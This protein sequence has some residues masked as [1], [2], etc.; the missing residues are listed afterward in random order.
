MEL[1]VAGRTVSTTEAVEVLQ[2]YP[3]GTIRWY[4][5]A[6]AGPEAA[7]EVTLADLGRLAIINAD[8]SG[9]DAV[10]LLELGRSAPW[11]RVATD[12]DLVEAD[13]E[14][15]GGLYDDAVALYDHFVSH[16]GI[17]PAKASKLLHLKRPHLYPILDSQVMAFYDRS[18]RDAAAAS[19]REAH[20]MYWAAIRNDLIANQAAL[21]SLRSE[22]DDGELRQLG[23]L[24]LLDI[25]AWWLS[26]HPEDDHA[27]R[28]V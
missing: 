6:P 4:D 9:N 28:S 1:T 5:L 19:S 15:R 25:L 16:P 17:G 2:G 18:A 10:A 20:R 11:D 21:S 27:A 12:A 22:L 7:N 24:R 8:L 13:P 23:N 26:T 14:G 3:R